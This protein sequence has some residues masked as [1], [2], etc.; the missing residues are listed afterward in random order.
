MS[1]RK[2]RR[3]S[4][5]LQDGAKVLLGVGSTVAIGG[6]FAMGC[7][8]RP[9]DTVEPRT[10]ST[11]VQRL[12]QSSVDKIDVL[13]VIDN[14]GSMADKQAVLADA[15]PQLVRRLVFPQCVDADGVPEPNGA[16]VATGECPDGYTPEFQPIQDINIGIISSS[17][18]SAGTPV[19]EPNAS[20]PNNQDLGH[21]LSRTTPGTPPEANADLTYKNLGFLAWDPMGD[22][23]GT[24][25]SEALIDT[26][27]SMVQGV[28]EVGCGF[29]APLEAAYRFLVDPEPWA[30]FESRGKPTGEDQVVID[31]REAFLRPDSL[32]AVIILTDENDCSIRNDSVGHILAAPQPDT[33]PDFGYSMP[34]PREECATNPDDKCC[35]S[36]IEPVPD[37]CSGDGGCPGPAGQ[38]VPEN[39][40][41]MNAPAGELD[42]NNIFLRCHD[43]KRRFGIDFLYP[44]R[45]YIN[46]FSQPLINT[47]SL[48]LTTDGESDVANPLFKGNRGS[49][50]V[51]VAGI[52]GVPWQLIAR[53]NGEGNPDLLQGLNSENQAIGGFQTFSEL[54]TNGV[55][56]KL[57]PKDGADA[58]DDPHMIE[59][60]FPRDGLS[61]TPGS[62]EFNGNEYETD[63]KDLQY[64]CIFD[65][66]ADFQRDCAGGGSSCDCAD[67]GNPQGKPLC[68]DQLQVK[69]KA[70]PGTRILQMLNGLREQ[71]IPASICPAQL[72]TQDANDYGYTPAVFAIIDRL[73]TKLGGACQ[74][75]QLFADE[76]GNVPCIVIEARDSDGDG[77]AGTDAKC[78]CDLAARKDPE[79]GAA[80]AADQIRSELANEEPSPGYDCLCEVTQLDGDARTSCQN[81]DLPPNDVDGW[82][83]VDAT[84]VPQVGNPALVSSCPASEQRLVRF[85]GE[86]EVK[87]GGRLYI[88]CS[89]EQKPTQ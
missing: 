74:P 75:R 12:T 78:N 45:R 48:E 76:D 3:L 36:C 49:D 40:F 20:G 65:L 7:L 33:D 5:K 25:D 73:K 56:D 26:L 72:T 35:V 14:S 84:S 88:T 58:A 46:A 71:G 54:D 11:N 87:G 57:I 19:C 82:C 21:L 52:V 28:G 27:R 29:E 42:Q 34:R 81:E 9:I 80:V 44:V 18:G 32:V 51:F 39:F 55:W 38:A 6:G 47:R 53:K 77:D 30:G 22:R 17:L 67:E 83:Y 60:A 2:T 16:T 31:Q 1:E 43:P 15:V 8:D 79:G 59:S 4:R 23:D 63:F 62:S 68:D 10:T 85:V 61:T 24:T 50:L 86:G 13:L 64:A 70:Y 89:G 66:P 41:P 37:G 69:A